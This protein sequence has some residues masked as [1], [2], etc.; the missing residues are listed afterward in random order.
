MWRVAVLHHGS[1]SSLALTGLR[2]G[3]HRRG[4]IDGA[5]CVVDA[6]GVEGRW[7]RLPMLVEQLLQRGPH[8]I[9]AIGAVAALAA[10]RATARVPILHTIVLDPPDIGLTAR[11]VT[12]VSTFDPD[13]ATRHLRLLQQL[14][15]GLRKVAF[16]TDV[17]APRG[18]DGLNPLVSRL[19]LA[20]AVHG[21]ETT[22]VALSGIDADIEDAFDS[23][24]RAHA[25]GL[26][27]LE[28]PAV[29]ARLGDIVRLAERHRLPTLTPFGWPD[30]GV[31]MQGAAL[32]DA[33]DPLAEYVAA[34]YRGACVADVPLRSVRH[35]RLVI[36]RGQAQRIGLLVPAR[37]LD[38]VTQF[39]DY[40]PSDDAR[41]RN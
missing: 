15:P 3:L 2:K 33:I 17:D 10:Q 28:V 35:E 19:L 4:L 11:N 26:V 25:Q 32:H 30:T 21:I 41:G 20:A 8:V 16:L 1:P 9:V 38:R 22:C 34:L 24:L 6:V 37:V 23:V 31:V 27:A 39:I 40:K 14:V 13:Q 5:N 36:H 12:G 7:V 29:L 18:P